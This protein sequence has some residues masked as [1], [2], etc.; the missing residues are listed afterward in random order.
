MKSSYGMMNKLYKTP[1]Y[2]R[3]INALRTGKLNLFQMEKLLQLK[4]SNEAA[5]KIAVML[6][7]IG[8]HYPLYEVDQP[9]TY[10]I[11]YV[12]KYEEIH[13]ARIRE[14]EEIGF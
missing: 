8:L 2:S 6:E 10:T 14:E 11:D 4:H 7:N 3:L 13:A 9:G 12:K 5:I 1:A